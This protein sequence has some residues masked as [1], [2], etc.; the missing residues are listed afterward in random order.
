MSHSSRPSPYHGGIRHTTQVAAF[1]FSNY[2]ARKRH[3]RDLVTWGRS[4][5]NKPKILGSVMCSG[6]VHRLKSS[7]HCKRCSY[8][9]CCGGD[10]PTCLIVPQ[11]RRSR[12]VG[13]G[14]AMHKGLQEST[15]YFLLPSESFMQNINKHVSHCCGIAGRTIVCVLC[16]LVV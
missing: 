9:S 16:N 7:I 14:L 13:D 10:S 3:R 6:L 8:R 11:R 12:M 2:V 4:R 15:S 5:S 1:F